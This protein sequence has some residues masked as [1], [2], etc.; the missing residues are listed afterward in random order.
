MFSGVAHATFFSLKLPMT[1]GPY[2]KRVTIVNYASGSV[3][4]DHSMLSF[5]SIIYFA[6][7]EHYVNLTT[8]LSTNL[9]DLFTQS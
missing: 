8:A 9:K 7:Q 2:Y 6:V 1:S 3:I 5:F 4:Y